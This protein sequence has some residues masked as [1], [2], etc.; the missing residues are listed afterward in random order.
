MAADLPENY[1]A[2][3]AAFKFIRQVPADWQDSRTL[4]GEIGDYIV[5]ARRDRNSLDWYLGAITDENPRQLKV[6]LD[7]LGDCDCR[8]EIYADGPAADYDTILMTLSPAHRRLPAQ[9]FLP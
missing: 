9:I 6:P 1:L 2:R 7:F 4:Q 5:V 3:P 8:A